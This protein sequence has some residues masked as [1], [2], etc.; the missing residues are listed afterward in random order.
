MSKSLCQI[1]PVIVITC[2]RFVLAL[3]IAW[4]FKRNPLV[5]LGLF[6]LAEFTDLLDGFLAR[7]YS[8]TTKYGALL[9]PLA[10]KAILL[11]SLYGLW[12]AHLIPGWI[13]AIVVIR[14]TLALTGATL[15]LKGAN[16]LPANILG[17]VTAWLFAFAIVSLPFWQTFGMYML[18]LAITGMFVAF[19]SYA[20]EF[21]RIARGR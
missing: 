8:L 16:I 12:Q 15:L 14:D 20:W 2:L 4:L 5:A 3:P 19:I 6:L 17:K 9:D 7:R 18:G 10:D 21:Y 1:N 13:F 11:A